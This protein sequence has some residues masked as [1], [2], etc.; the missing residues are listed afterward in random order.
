MKLQQKNH[1]K[2]SK[3]SIKATW[4]KQVVFHGNKLKVPENA[5]YLVV[6]QERDVVYAYESEPHLV[7]DSTHISNKDWVVKF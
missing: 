1:L 7:T 6:S 3:G 5:N 4:T 2:L